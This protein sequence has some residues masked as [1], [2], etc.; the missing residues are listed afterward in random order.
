[1]PGCGKSFLGKHLSEHYKIKLLELDEKI[2]KENK[3]TL[4]EI[5]NQYG[6]DKFNKIEERSL[7]SIDFNS[8][9]QQIISTGGSVIYCKKGMEYLKRN[10]NL[11]V[12]LDTDYDILVTRTNNFTN[13]G[14][15]FNGLTPYELYQNRCLLY[16][17]Y[18]DIKIKT[19]NSLEFL[20][21]MFRYLQ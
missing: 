3:L 18:C 19:N 14:I 1:M 8:Q 20:I 6:E 2:E 16:N 4:F 11:I 17:K 10:N 5:I 15:V 13:R 9:Q 12:F 7:L 21:N